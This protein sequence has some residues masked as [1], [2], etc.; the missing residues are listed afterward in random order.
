MFCLF[1][2]GNHKTQK[3]ANRIFLNFIESAIAEVYEMKMTLMFFSEVDYQIADPSLF[4]GT[5]K[6]ATA[7]ESKPELQIDSVCPSLPHY[8]ELCQSDGYGG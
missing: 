5:L 3:N 1:W 6:N 2:G 7:W 4:G 8:D